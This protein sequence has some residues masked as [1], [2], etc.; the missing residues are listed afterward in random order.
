VFE[1]DRP[2]STSRL[3][4]EV[5][6]RSLERTQEVR[7]EVS[8]DHGRTYRQVLAQEYNFSPH[9]ATFQHEE[10]RFEFSD[11]THLRL[12][13]VPNKMGSG[14]EH[15]GIQTLASDMGREH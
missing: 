13:I 1:F 3:A 15:G 7:V 4:Y 10:L 5:E 6:E 2:Q 9:G 8:C 11:I 14:V 12:T